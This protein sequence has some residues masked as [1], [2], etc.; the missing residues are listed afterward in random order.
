MS[1]ISH[2]EIWERMVFKWCQLLI[3]IPNHIDQSDRWWATILKF[4]CLVQVVSRM[5]AIYEYEDG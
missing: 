1:A 2:L 4:F 3:F 5:K